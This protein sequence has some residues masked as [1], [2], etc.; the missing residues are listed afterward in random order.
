MDPHRLARRYMALHALDGS[1]ECC[2]LRHWRGQWWR[3]DG[4]YRILEEETFRVA[5]GAALKAIIDGDRLV[6]R[7]GNAY[8]VTTTRVNNVALALAGIVS[9]DESRDQ[10]MWLKA[11][12]DKTFLAIANGLLDLT[13]KTSPT[14]IPA[15]PLWFSP[16]RLPVR[17]DPASTCPRWLAFLDR[18]LEGDAERIAL[19]QE[20]F[21]YNL[22]FDTSYQRFMMFLGEGANGKSVVTST[23]ENLLGA[24]NVSNVPLELFGDRFQLAPSIGKLANIVSEVTSVSKVD[25]GRL[26]EFTAGDS[27]S[28]D[29]KYLTP[30]QTKPTA[31]LTIATNNLP[32]IGDR[33]EGVWRRLMLMPFNVVI[34][35]G[36]RDPLLT[37]KLKAELSGVLNWALE[38]LRRLQQ[39]GHFTVPSV[40]TASVTEYKEESNPVKQFLDECCISEPDATYPC[41]HI[42]IQYQL[43][44]KA[45]GYK[46]LDERQ[47]GKDLKRVFPKVQRNR[48]QENQQRGYFYDGL[49]VQVPYVPEGSL[50]WSDSEDD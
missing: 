44:C 34:P 49:K 5:L 23:L 43:W 22:V 28:F 45:R 12:E 24:E 13:A 47:F 35:E 32:R 2:T 20:W 25:E 26:K 14:L 16:V 42:Y 31:R 37:D 8:Q 46:P 27:M 4:R 38:G 6:D 17:Y 9:V 18:V 10:P 40:N 29:R 30:L 19:L 1:E 39:Q 50:P 15:S 3:W 11:G 21:G 7:N 33:S 41:A 48:R 36:E